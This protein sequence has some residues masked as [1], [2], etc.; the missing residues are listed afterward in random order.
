MLSLP[1]IQPLDE[2]RLGVAL[3]ALAA[4]DADIGEAVLRIGHPVPRVR[5][6]GFTTLLRIITAQQLSTKA[7]AAI[8]GRLEQTLGG[9]VTADAFL[10][11]SDEDL[12]RIGFSV[13]KAIY[14]RDLAR[15]IDDGRLPV[16]DLH[17]MEDEEVIARITALKGFGRW[18]AEIYLLFALGR[19][20]CFPADDLALQVGAQ[21]LKRLEEWPNGKALRLLAECWQPYRGAAAVFLWHYYGAATLDERR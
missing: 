4:L 10:G 11:L 14:G 20:D 12:R 15:A 6:P 3:T 21:R 16:A 18:S 7:A 19:I 9:M 2:A 8:W 17:A 1:A 13:R 5:D